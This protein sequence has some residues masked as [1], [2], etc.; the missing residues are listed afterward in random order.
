MLT[1]PLEFSMTG[2]LEDIVPVI[3]MEPL[4]FTSSVALPTACGEPR[5]LVLEIAMLPE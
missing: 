3:V 2:A 5:V 4:F 1:A